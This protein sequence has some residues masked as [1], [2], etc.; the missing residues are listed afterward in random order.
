MANAAGLLKATTFNLHLEALTHS[1]DSPTSLRHK[2]WIWW[3]AWCWSA[4]ARGARRWLLDGEG[5][6][7]DDK[8]LASQHG[9]S[10]DSR[11]G[12]RRCCPFDMCSKSIRLRHRQEHSRR[13]LGSTSITIT[14]SLPIPLPLL[15]FT[16]FFFY[17]FFFCWTLFSIFLSC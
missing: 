1:I 16:F 10:S 12:R 7:L 13:C 8:V 2:R 15:S 4:I 14:V 3:I 9:S 6:G 5:E 17:F 11:R